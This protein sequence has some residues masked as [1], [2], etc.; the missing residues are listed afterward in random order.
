M[1]SYEHNNKR[2]DIK[3]KKDLTIIKL[4][5]LIQDLE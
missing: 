5:Q 2:N 4:Q 3:L 1:E